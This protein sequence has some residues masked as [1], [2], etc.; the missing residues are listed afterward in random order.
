MDTA[1]TAPTIMDPRITA[2]AIAVMAAG[3]AAMMSVHTAEAL[4]QA[5]G[6]SRRYQSAE[7]G[8]AAEA[9][10]MAAAGVV[11]TVA[12]A[13]IQEVVGTAA[14]DTADDRVRADLRRGSS[15]HSRSGPSR[16]GW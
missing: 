8:Q 3:D 15:R 13:A 12:A 11:F 10:F 5:A 4:V 2:A 16:W 1:A 6:R 7:A 9:A 14:V